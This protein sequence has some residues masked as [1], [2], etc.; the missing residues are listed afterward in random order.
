[1]MKAEMDLVR[2][3]HE[4]VMHEIPGRRPGDE[5]GNQYQ[6]GKFIGYKQDDPP[7]AGTCHLPDP[8]FPGPLFHGIR[9][10]P[11]DPEGCNHNG[12]KREDDEKPDRRDWLGTGH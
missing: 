9:G 5:V 12:Q 8:D 1:M 7:G 2:K 6:S 11:E 10:E 3:V 4:P